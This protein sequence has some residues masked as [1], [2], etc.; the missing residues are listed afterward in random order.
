MKLSVLCSKSFPVAK[1]LKIREGEYQGLPSKSFC[2]TVP[3]SFVGNPCVLCFT[4]FTVAKRLGLWGD[5]QDFHWKIFC[6]TVPKVS[7]GGNSLVFQNFRV[8]KKFGLE[9][10]G[11]ESRFSVEKILSQD[12]VKFLT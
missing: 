10:A 6:P 11:G 8:S 7:L 1:S 3:K 9:S 12:V 5:C 4:K 2:L